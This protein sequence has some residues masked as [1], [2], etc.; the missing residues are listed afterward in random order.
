[1]TIHS[2]M[3]DNTAKRKMRGCLQPFTVKELVRNHNFDLLSKI[4]KIWNADVGNR[5]MNRSDG[6]FVTGE[7]VILEDFGSWLSQEAWE[8]RSGYYIKIRMTPL[9]AHSSIV[10][11]RARAVVDSFIELFP[12]GNVE[13]AENLEILDVGD[14]GFQ[15]KQKLGLTKTITVVVETDRYSIGD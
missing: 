8:D 9:F 6:G 12:E 14:V 1:M 11:G 2:D 3:F 5:I 7:S 4:N 15:E 13:F 10:Q